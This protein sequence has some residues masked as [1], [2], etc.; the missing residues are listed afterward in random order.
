[1]RNDDRENGP[2]T[3]SAGKLP[4]PPPAL[5]PCSREDCRQSR[6]W[7]P[8]DILWFDGQEE[9]LDKAGNI[10]RRKVAAGWYCVECASDLEIEPAGPRLD[11]VLRAEGREDLEGEKRADPACAECAFYGGNAK[12]STDAASGE[13]LESTHGIGEAD[14]CHPTSLI[15]HG[16]GVYD[17]AAGMRRGWCGRRGMLFTPWPRRQKQQKVRARVLT[18]GQVTPIGAMQRVRIALDGDGRSE[19]ECLVGATT[20]QKV[21]LAPGVACTAALSHRPDGKPELGEWER[22][23]TASDR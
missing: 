14:C 20:V 22:A 1:M 17:S 18:I 23:D 6:T 11:E 13:L 5:Y 16:N 2:R 9:T 15:V 4:A 19:I 7:P 3:D 21:G 12:A 10:D 8:D